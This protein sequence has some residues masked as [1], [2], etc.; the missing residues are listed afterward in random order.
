MHY[1]GLDFINLNKMLPIIS[2]E[3]FDLSIH[4]FMTD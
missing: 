3:N 2:K 4:N 1:K